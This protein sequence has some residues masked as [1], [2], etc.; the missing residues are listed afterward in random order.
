[1]FARTILGAAAAAVAFASA[2]ALAQQKL[3][4]ILN[5]VPGGDHAPYYYAKKLGWYAKEGI[6]LNIEP[7]KGSALAVQKVGAG[8][9]PIGLADMGGVLIAK[10]KGADTVAV[11]NVYANSPQGMYWLKSSGIK[12]V[13]DFPGKKIGNPAADGSRAMWPAL[14]KANGIDPKSVTWVNIDPNAK[15]AALKA[16]SIDVTTSFYNIHH[17]FQREIGDDLGFLAWRDA[18]LN[19]YGNSIIVNAKFL[20]G[21]RE[22]IGKFVK[23][24][25]RAFA[26]C[27][28]EPE[29]CV[30]ALVDANGALKFDNELTNW[31]LVEVLMSDKFAREMALGI[32]E[33]GR[34]KADYELVRDY[35]GL[36]KPFDVKTVYTNEFLDRSIRMTK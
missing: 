32:H 35:I 36:D 7:G 16:K 19:P 18:G 5:W 28:K 13:K 31:K 4:F 15:L 9:N 22:T 20:E 6:D 1:M 30:Q 26:A 29:P 17:V 21:N 34:M 33:D 25:Q 27:V 23:V 10:G 12:G 24:T 14:A 11:Y 8:A 2:P 3:D